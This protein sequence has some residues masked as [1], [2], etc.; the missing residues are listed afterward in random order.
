VL[1]RL[2]RKQERNAALVADSACDQQHKMLDA[3][4]QSTL[5][6]FS[7]MCALDL[8]QIAVEDQAGRAAGYDL[9]GIV[10]L[11]GKIRATIAVS[12][13]KSLAFAATES[14]LGTRPDEINGD[15]VD[16]VG[17]LTNMIGGN[18]KDRFALKGVNLGL[19][20]VVA[21]QGHYVAFES[22]LDRSHLQFQSQFGRLH[23]ELG[24]L[25]T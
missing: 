16:L 23:I 17:E 3:L 4:V 10:S 1:A 21:G 24:M 9:S 22:G 2:N 8:E 7:S 5:S 12:L 25:P 20:T 11:S 15:V 18:A 6:L 19:P 14:F 13:D